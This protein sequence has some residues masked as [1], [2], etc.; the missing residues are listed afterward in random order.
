MIKETSGDDYE[1]ARSLNQ[2]LTFKFC[3]DEF[4]LAGLKFKKEQMRSL[5]FIKDDLLYSN[6]ACLLSE[7]C[8]HTIKIAVFEGT[9][10]N[11]FKDRFE[12]SGSL[13]KQM[14]ECF[15]YIDKNNRIRSEIAGL[16][17]IDHRD[18]PQIAIR[19][20]LLNALVH[21]D[22]SFS[23]STLISIFDDR[24][25]IVTIGGLLRGISMEDMTLGVSI[26]RNKNLANVFFRLKLIEAYGTGVLKIIES[27]KPFPGMEPL[28]ETTDNAFKITIF[29]TNHKHHKI[30][31][32][33]NKSL[34]ETENKI[35]NHFKDSEK[36]KRV[37]VENLLS[38]SRTMA[39]NHIKS[40]LEKEV[41]I[42]Q[43]SGKN[44]VYLLNVEM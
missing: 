21:R 11:I 7:Q 40:L 15:D 29:N 41:L 36:F 32:V 5:H 39:T 13:F 34:T 43:G 4:A 20:A 12:F 33:N 38:I 10:K 3:K 22:Y 23:A 2:N 6:L 42:A 24:I 8:V 19:E 35:V 44:T 31:H 28:I 9:N 18:Y 25:E 27:Y 26:L 17:R 30:K 16:T 37:D 1:D 14:R